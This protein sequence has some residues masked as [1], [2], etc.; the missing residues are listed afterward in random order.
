MHDRVAWRWRLYLT[1]VQMQSVAYLLWLRQ[2]T[3]SAA[4]VRRFS[5]DYDIP[6]PADGLVLFSPGAAGRP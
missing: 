1:A 2:V 4:E 6:F 3:G 5:R